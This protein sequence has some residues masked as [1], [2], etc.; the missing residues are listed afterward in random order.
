MEW[1]GL[2]AR[3]ISVSKP[4]RYARKRI[5]LRV[6]LT[7]LYVSK[8]YRYARKTLARSV[9]QKLATE[10]Q[11]LIGMLGSSCRA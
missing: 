1:G 8:P 3:E 5:L 10:F 7:M 6:Y 11:N 9:V 4:Y 2:T